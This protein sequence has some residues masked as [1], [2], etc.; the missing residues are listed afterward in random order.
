MIVS[1][2]GI[3]FLNDSILLL[4]KRK[5]MWVLPKG[6]VEQGETTIQAAVREVKE[7]TGIDVDVIGKANST[8]YSFYSN[9]LKLDKKVIWF[10]MKAVSTKA[11]PQIEEGF[12]AAKFIKLSKIDKN[13][14]YDSEYE[15]IR[16]Y[17]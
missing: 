3:V 5:G 9:N 2:G 16:E 6:R 13:K 15:L 4:K 7:E 10:T 12:I 8:Y 11:K 17:I 1:A 14:M